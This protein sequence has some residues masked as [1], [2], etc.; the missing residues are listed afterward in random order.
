MHDI[1]LD[2]WKMRGGKLFQDQMIAG[3][4]ESDFLVFMVSDNSLKSNAVSVEWKTKFSE[5]LSFG[6]DRV[7]PFLID[8]TP[9]E[10]LPPYLQNIFSYRYD[11]KEQNIIKL[12]E[13][14]L[15]WKS[16]Q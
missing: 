8:G 15:F 4:N 9:F 6:E 7:F 3:I 5:K 11:N 14:I 12:V 10:S 2:K 1:W 13:D 16:E